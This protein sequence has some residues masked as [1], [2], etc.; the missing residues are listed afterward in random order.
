MDKILTYEY[1]EYLDIFILKICKFVQNNPSLY[2]Q[3]FIIINKTLWRPS[4]N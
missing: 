2:G 4:P 3:L 1:I